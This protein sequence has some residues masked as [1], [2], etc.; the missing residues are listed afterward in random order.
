MTELNES[1]RD[2]IDTGVAPVSA[3]EILATR[4]V[5]QTRTTV[6]WARPRL[7]HRRVLVLSAIAA[8]VIA[9]ASVGLVTVPGTKN[10]NIAPA[11]AATFLESVAVT[12]ASEKPV[13]PGPGQYLYVA[14]IASMT[15]GASQHPSPKMFWY[16]SNELHQVWTSPQAPDHQT[17]VVV[18]RPEFLSA[19]DRA[20]WVTDGSPLLGSGNSSGPA[21]P[22]YDIAGLP[23]R[24]AE[25]V[26]YFRSQHYLPSESSYGTL[27]SW[28]FDMA[29][30]FLQSGAS[31]AQRAALLKFVATIPGVRLLGHATSIVTRKRGSV[32][33]LPLRAYGKAEEAIFDSSTSKLIE[34]RYILTVL[35]S[36]PSPL[37]GPTPFEGEIQSYSDFVFAG[38]TRAN[39]KYSLPEDT[40]KF[41]QVWPFGS[42]REP[43]PG[44][45]GQ[46]RP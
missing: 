16:D 14:T 41:P 23:T 24:A 45:L 22:Y 29:L 36:K 9:L 35:P 7:R 46:A 11:S 43:L 39:S 27:P 3:E 2:F 34:V 37:P 40:P 28:E 33:A 8:L 10:V 4:P 5:A 26:A 18:G 1:I 31:S 44:W 20:I 38:I 17:S 25:M 21:P 32:I 12:A 6:D 15:N 13:V 42:V 30:G 19:A